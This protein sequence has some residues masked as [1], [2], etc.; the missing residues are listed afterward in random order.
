E[1]LVEKLLSNQ[2]IQRDDDDA[3]L[4]RVLG[5]DSKLSIPNLEAGFELEYFKRRAAAAPEIQWID[6]ERS[7]HTPPGGRVVLDTQIV[8]LPPTSERDGTGGRISA[9]PLDKDPWVRP[10]QSNTVKRKP[11]INDVMTGSSAG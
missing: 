3:E 11:S 4:T 8:S 7:I 2:P 6:L 1:L 5:P 9:I 10:S